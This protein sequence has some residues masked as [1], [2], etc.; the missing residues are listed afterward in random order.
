MMLILW[1]LLEWIVFCRGPRNVAAAT[2]KE[3]L[4]GVW[5]KFECASTNRSRRMRY[6]QI[7]TIEEALVDAL[8]MHMSP[9]ISEPNPSMEES[10]EE[11]ET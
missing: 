7:E 3:A 5:A 1:F 2:A 8:K 11:E 4:D 9:S 10:E 6:P